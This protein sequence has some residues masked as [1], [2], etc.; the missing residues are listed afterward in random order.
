M[1]LL[2]VLVAIFIWCLLHSY[3]HSDRRYQRMQ[4]SFKDDNFGPQWKAYF[5]FFDNLNYYTLW[6]RGK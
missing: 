3:L 4:N 1:I 6:K 2:I 5:K